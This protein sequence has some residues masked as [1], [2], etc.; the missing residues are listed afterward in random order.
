[1]KLFV[2]PSEVSKKSKNPKHIEVKQK[3]AVTSTFTK[4]VLELPALF[5]DLEAE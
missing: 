3:F 4:G 5:P 2:S 1:V